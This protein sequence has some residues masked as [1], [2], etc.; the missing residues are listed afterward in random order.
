MKFIGE[1]NNF[2]TTSKLSHF[3]TSHG[4]LTGDFSHEFTPMPN[5]HKHMHSLAFTK[6][7]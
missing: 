6:E 7:K 3:T 5:V 4:T 1:T 2:T